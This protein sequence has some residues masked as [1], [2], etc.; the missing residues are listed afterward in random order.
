MKVKVC[1]LR[2][3]VDADAAIGMGATHVGVVLAED[4]PRCATRQEARDIV[5]IARGRAE[6]VS[7]KIKL[8]D[9]GLGAMLS[10]FHKSGRFCGTPDYAAPET[11]KG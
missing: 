4:S 6:V 7:M 1:G 3:A 2:R 5:Q 9:W 10:G 11:Y 8:I